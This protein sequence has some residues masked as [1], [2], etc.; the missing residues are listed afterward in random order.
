MK[1][2]TPI[3]GVLGFDLDKTL[4]DGEGVDFEDPDSIRSRVRPHGSA[5]CRVRQL[6]KHGYAIAYITGR[7][8]KHR[9][10]TIGQLA[11]AGLPGGALAMNA[12]WLGYEAMAGFKAGV[13]LELVQQAAA[14]GLRVERYVGDHAADA[15]A[16]RHAGV[17]F[18]HA[19]DF[20]TGTLPVHILAAAPTPRSVAA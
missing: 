9:S 15:W 14:Q 16:A 19:N 20:R 10:L 5:V 3:R 17:P 7:S 12:E 11:D 8:R 2:S 6:W 13:L 18:L 1:A 4:F